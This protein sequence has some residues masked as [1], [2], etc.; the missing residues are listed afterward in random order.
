VISDKASDVMPQWS[1]DG[2]SL[3]F[4]RQTLNANGTVASSLLTILDLQSKVLSGLPGSENL[5]NPSWSPDGRYVAAL[6]DDG[7]KL[8]VLHLQSQPWSELTT[9]VGFAAGPFW[10]RDSTCVYVQEVWSGAEQPIFKVRVKDSKKELVATT[11]QLVRNDTLGYALVGLAPDDSP[12]A[13]L[14]VRD[15]DIYALEFDFP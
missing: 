1:P 15:T 12:V 7:R 9:G 13:T 14:L 6:S 8:V 5:M 11:K 3:L 4:Q 2:R 10:T